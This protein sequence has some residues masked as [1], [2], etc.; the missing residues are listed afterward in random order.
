MLLD[1]TGW[2]RGWSM[3]TALVGLRL[4]LCNDMDVRLPLCLPSQ[5]PFPNP[6]CS[7]ERPCLNT[8]DLWLAGG[9]PVEARFSL[10]MTSSLRQTDFLCGGT[11]QRTETGWKKSS[12]VK[13]T[14]LSNLPRAQK[15]RVREREKCQYFPSSLNL[16]FVIYEFNSRDRS[17]FL[18]CSQV[19]LPRASASCSLKSTIYHSVLQMLLR[20]V[21]EKGVSLEAARTGS[22]YFRLQRRWG[23]GQGSSGLCS[24]GLCRA[25]GRNVCNPPTH[26][27][28]LSVP[29]Q[30]NKWRQGRTCV[31]SQDARFGFESLPCG[32]DALFQKQALSPPG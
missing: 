11:Q 30:V 20:G 10:L 16:W 2:G 27:G 15:V 32:S 8:R 19:P 3:P 24:S 7:Q 25:W 28:E 14:L 4:C 22:R 31:P 29:P 23:G 21:C 26:P 1:R 9:R 6:F 13:A 17:I 12:R 18:C 5:L